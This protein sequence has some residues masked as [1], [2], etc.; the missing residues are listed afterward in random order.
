MSRFIDAEPRYI[1]ADSLKQKWLFLG[2]D[3]KPYRDEI[4]AMPTADVVPY[5]IEDGKITIDLSEIID[6]IHGCAIKLYFG[7]SGADMREV[8]GEPIPHWRGQM[9][10]CL[11]FQKEKQDEQIY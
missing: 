11:P 3:G 7:K 10:G 9:D 5:F 1:D 6:K 4:D 2:K 8:A